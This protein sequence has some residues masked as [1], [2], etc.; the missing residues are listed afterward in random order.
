M[1]QAIHLL[2]FLVGAVLL[3]AELLWHDPTRPLVVVL[4]LV[5]IGVITGEQLR[6][7]LDARSSEA[8]ARL[9]DRAAPPR[10]FSD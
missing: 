6:R 4:A 2:T 10:P 3:L 7:Y 9:D 8:R 5:L 1:D